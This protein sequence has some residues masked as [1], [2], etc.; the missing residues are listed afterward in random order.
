MLFN[1]FFIISHTI[2]LFAIGFYLISS[3]Q[4]FNY[5]FERVIFNYKKPL[6][7]L[8]FFIIPIS[9]YY[10]QYKTLF[11][12][13]YEYL[14]FLPH[15]FLWYRKLDKKL[16]FTA[17]VKRFFL[18]LGVITIFYDMLSFILKANLGLIIPLSLAYLASSIYEKILFESFKKE[19]LKKI[20]N[21]RR[22]GLKIVAIT[23][24]YG[25][26]SIKNILYQLIEEEF[27]TYK[28]PRSVNTLGGLVKDVNQNLPEKTEIYIAE[29]GARRE[30]DILEITN[31]LKPEFAIVGK[32]GEQHIEYFKK[33]EN[34]RDTKMEIIKSPNLKK[35]FIDKSANIKPYKNIEE[36]GNELSNIEASLDGISFDILI[37]GKRENFKS[38]LLGDFN[39]I[40]IGLAI[41][42][43]K[44]LGVDSEK[45]KKRVAKLKPI[46]HRLERIEAGGKI[47]IDDSFN[48]NYE[49]MVS[50][51]KIVNQYRGRKV[52]ITPG[53]VESNRETNISLAKE[54]D[55]IFDLVIIT[56]EL[57][58]KILDR[59]IERAKKIILKDKSKLENLLA[60]ETKEG[61]LI[62][63][64]NDTP[65]FF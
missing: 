25:K 2:F 56:G 9:I 20:E 52:L 39:A 13:L 27:K 33:L 15:L 19:A 3:L 28:T 17:R 38:P 23:A 65:N 48:G 21:M 4:W 12:L 36:F 31:F 59:N 61:D 34:I 50:S 18:F 10:L 42:M 6:W 60:K 57:N 5:K 58:S 55:K 37:D 29:A 7:H 64:S 47:I 46:E 45:I 43:A 51:Y 26:T 63:F 44:E 49:G 16:V 14:I 35:A 32:I 53:I 40:N 24:S 41:K 30:G 22:N 62:L 8:Y 11:L 1:L 54:I